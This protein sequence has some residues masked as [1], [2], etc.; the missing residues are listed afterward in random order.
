MPN[1]ELVQMICVA[2]LAAAISGLSGYHISRYFHSTNH[3]KSDTRGDFGAP[4]GGFLAVLSGALVG[5]LFFRLF[6]TLILPEGTEAIAF[7]VCMIVGCI[8]GFRGMND[9]NAKGGS[10]KDKK[11]S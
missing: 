10:D 6:G 7:V 8:A 2:V 3:G 11:D 9:G 4:R 1:I 5:T